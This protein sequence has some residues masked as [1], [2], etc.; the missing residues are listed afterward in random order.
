MC[1]G[2][3]G[4]SDLF[5]FST[6]RRAVASLHTVFT[7]RPRHDFFQY[8]YEVLRGFVDLDLKIVD[9][10]EL[11]F[12]F[13]DTANVPECVWAI[14]VKDELKSIKAN[15]WDVVR[16]A[17]TIHLSLDRSLFVA[18]LHSYHGQPQPPAFTDGHVR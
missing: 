15:R 9:E 7:L 14:V 13:Q 8:A 10:V 6:G 12:T 2:T 1:A 18:E 5:Q 11:D 4:N 17:D 3:D 16:L